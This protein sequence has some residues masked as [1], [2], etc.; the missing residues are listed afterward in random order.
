M[1]VH[2]LNCATMCPYGGRWLGGTGGEVHGPAGE[3]WF[4]FSA[5]RAVG[6]DDG[7]VLLVPMP[8]HTRGHACVAVRDGA[9]GRWLLHAGDA[10]FHHDELHAETPACPPGL[11]LF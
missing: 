9:R 10:Y 5:V 6:D 3:S 8:G 11:A 2:H 7:D 1:R 4:G